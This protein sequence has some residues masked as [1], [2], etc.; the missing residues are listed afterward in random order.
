MSYLSQPSCG[1]EAKGDGGCGDQARAD[2]KLHKFIPSGPEIL[3]LPVQLSVLKISFFLP[4][5]FHI[6]SFP[7]LA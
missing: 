2:L 5:P 7:L 4:F 6:G 1:E 3:P